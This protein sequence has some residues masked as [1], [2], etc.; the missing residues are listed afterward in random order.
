VKDPAV[1][2]ALSRIELE[3]AALPGLRLTAS[4]INRLCNLPEDV[5]E[6]A[7]VALT[8]AGFLQVADGVFLRLRQKRARRAII[9]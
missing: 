7:L 6:S 8:K 1:L 4:Q 9:A 5:C 3:Y 2:K